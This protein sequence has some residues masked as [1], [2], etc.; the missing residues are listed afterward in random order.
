V[1]IIKT[2]ML[3]KIAGEI[4]TWISSDRSVS[5]EISAEVGRYVSI[6]EWNSHTP[7]QGNTN[8][9]IA[10]LKSQFRTDHIVA[11]GVGMNKEDPS[12]QYWLHQKKKGLINTLYDDEGEEVGE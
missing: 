3:L 4:R 5:A 12:W 8:K 1:K 6:Y 9:A 7:G 11:E 10:E 2:D